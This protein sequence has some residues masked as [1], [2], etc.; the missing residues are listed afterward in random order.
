M[1]AMFDHALLTVPF[2][3]CSLNWKVV[4]SGGGELKVRR[5]TVTF[6]LMGLVLTN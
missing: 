1:V 3:A 4:A 5:M 6:G 2:T